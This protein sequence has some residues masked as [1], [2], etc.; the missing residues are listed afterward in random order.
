MRVFTSGSRVTPKLRP[1]R[2]W[3]TCMAPP[4]PAHRCS[5]V[6]GAQTP[7]GKEEQ[8]RVRSVRKENPPNDTRKNSK[9]SYKYNSET[10]VRFYSCLSRCGVPFMS[11][12][13][14]REAAIWVSIRTLTTVS[15]VSAREAPFGDKY[16]ALVFYRNMYFNSF[17]YL[18]SLLI[19]LT[20]SLVFYG[21]SN[22]LITLLVFPV[23]VYA[24]CREDKL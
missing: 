18:G 1:V 17:E 22:K 21:C 8:N 6:N 19:S 9:L 10:L 16:K 20:I 11:V 13:F 23:I 4:T 2:E 3:L 24:V 14:M 12:F 5:N 7:R 15:F